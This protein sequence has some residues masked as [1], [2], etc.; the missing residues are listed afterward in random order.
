M[1]PEV[2][3]EEKILYKEESYVIQGAI[4]EVYRE[5]GPGFIEHVYQESLQIELRR[6]ASLSSQNSIWSWFT[7]A[8]F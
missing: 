6:R 1:D 3:A 2:I 8:K 5:M 7:K 4:F